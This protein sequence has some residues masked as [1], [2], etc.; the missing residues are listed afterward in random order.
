MNVKQAY[1]KFLLKA[2]TIYSLSE[3]AVIT[4]WVFESIAN[5]KKEDFIKH[6]EQEISKATSEQLNKAL[7]QVL[8]HKPIQYILGEGWFY[9]MK[10]KVNENV[11]IPRPETEELVEWIVTTATHQ[12]PAVS[13][14]DI[15][16]GSGCISIALKK[17]LHAATITAIDISK[18]ALDVANE[19]ALTQKAHVQFLEFNFLDESKWK[20]LPPFDMIVSNPPY[21]PIKEK[22][23][24][25]KNVTNYEP[26]T[27]LFVPD[28]E[29]LLFYKK[30]ADFGKEHLNY[31]GKIFVE[32]HV[33]YAEQTVTV[34]KERNYN[35][36]DLKKD[37][38]GR[39]RMIM[40]RL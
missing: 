4:D 33:D 5:V 40:A 23:G 11:L 10:L 16:T 6:P 29:P 36:V 39:D 22:E 34:F 32:V 21:I 17:H 14:L 25:D 31:N 30:I 3:G 15:G 9:N 35:Y 26:H 19:N 2:Q 24:L 1:K 38:Y 18:G 28:N 27:A 8:E 20:E 7:V 37:M 13:I 12:A